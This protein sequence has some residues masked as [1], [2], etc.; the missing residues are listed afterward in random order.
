MDNNLSEMLSKILE[1]EQMLNGLIN[2]AKTYMQKSE[3]SSGD[4]DTD[5]NVLPKASAEKTED[6]GTYPDAKNTASTQEA[7]NLIKELLSGANAGGKSANTS[8]LASREKI[9]F[10]NALKPFINKERQ[11]NID[12]LLKLLRLYDLAQNSGILTNLLKM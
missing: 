10:L 2:T 1:D 7:S 8:L 4:I 9:N 3:E 5:T 11:Q 12:Y 6:S